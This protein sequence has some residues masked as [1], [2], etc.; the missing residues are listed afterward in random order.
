M[1]ITPI[2]PGE[3]RRPPQPGKVT[4]R[5]RIGQCYYTLDTDDSPTA[6]ERLSTLIGLIAK[7]LHRHGIKVEVLS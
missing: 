2:T 6:V 7:G 4:R 3:V 5:L 1:N